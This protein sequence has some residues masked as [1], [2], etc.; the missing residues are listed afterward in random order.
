[1]SCHANRRFSVDG[2]YFLLFIFEESS[3][4]CETDHIIQAHQ[5]AE[6]L[7]AEGLFL[8]NRPKSVAN[9]SHSSRKTV[10]KRSL[11]SGN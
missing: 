10:A 7:V 3:F 9:Q 2:S 5:D 1:M 4:E 8:G 6:L 11:G